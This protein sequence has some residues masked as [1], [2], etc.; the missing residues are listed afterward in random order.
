LKARGQGAGFREC[1][2][3]FEKARGVCLVAE[4]EKDARSRLTREK[5]CVANSDTSRREIGVDETAR[6]PHKGCGPIG[7]SVKFLPC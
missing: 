3:F 5:R 7:V 1:L 4:K 6:R 2:L